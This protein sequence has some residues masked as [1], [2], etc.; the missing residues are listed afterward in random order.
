MVVIFNSLH[1]VYLQTSSACFLYVGS[2]GTILC[3]IS[4]ISL[5]FWQIKVQLIGQFLQ[6]INL[7]L[8]RKLNWSFFFKL[9]AG[10]Y[11]V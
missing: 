6:I 4:P 11:T 2:H 8:D 5:A 10:I 3:C 9:C 7:I 1:V